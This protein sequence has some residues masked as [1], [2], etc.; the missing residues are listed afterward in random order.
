MTQAQTQALQGRVALVTGGAQGIGRAIVERLA[1]DGAIV[2]VLDL[3]LALAEEAAAAL[4]AAGH[5]AMAFGG[6]VAQRDTVMNAAATLKEKFGRL[7]VLVSNAM[8][9]RYGPI[10]DLTPEA[11]GRMVGT[12]FNSVVWGIQAASLYMDQGGSVI[13]IAS[14]AAFLGIPQATIYCGV[15][16]G[17]LGLTRSAAVDLGPRGI[18]VNAIGPG[19]VATEGVKINLD[20]EKVKLRLAK[21]PLRRLGEVEDISSAV[22]FLASDQ[23]SWVTGECIKVDGGVTHAFL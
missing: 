16:A 8:W 19:S 17:V 3:K 21:T 18:R 13:N 15:K 2:G 12:G 11:V 7:D 20:P 9:V 4:R 23:S 1:S 5:Q 10:D 14:A 22:A 6:D